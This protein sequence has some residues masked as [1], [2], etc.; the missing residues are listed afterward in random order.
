MFNYDIMIVFN[1]DDYVFIIRIYSFIPNNKKIKSLH[2][3]NNNDYLILEL[4]QDSL[5]TKYKA[6]NIII[7]IL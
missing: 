1:N 7:I 3:F 4:R 2:K 6:Y 5:L